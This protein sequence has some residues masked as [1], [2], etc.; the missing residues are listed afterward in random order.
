VNKHHKHFSF[1][2]QVFLVLF[3]NSLYRAVHAL[4]IQKAGKHNSCCETKI[5]SIRGNEM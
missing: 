3:I 5:F 1:K 2:S 4:L